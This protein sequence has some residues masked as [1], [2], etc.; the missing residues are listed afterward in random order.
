MKLTKMY[1]NWF[2]S[3]KKEEN[4]PEDLSH[5]NIY[6]NAMAMSFHNPHHGG[7]PWGKENDFGPYTFREIT[8][9]GA[10][11]KYGGGVSS[12][13]KKDMTPMDHWNKALSHWVDALQST[14]N[15]FNTITDRGPDYPQVTV[16]TANNIYDNAKAHS[17][18]ASH[19][20]AEA[21]RKAFYLGHGLD[22]R[23]KPEEY[24]SWKPP[25]FE[26]VRKQ[27]LGAKNQGVIHT[28]S[29]NHSVI[30]SPFTNDKGE[31]MDLRALHKTHTELRD[32]LKL[33][34]VEQH[35]SD[36]FRDDPQRKHDVVMGLIGASRTHREVAN[37]INE[38]RIEEALTS[39]PSK[40]RIDFQRRFGHELPKN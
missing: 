34:A 39:K 36:T 35:N 23:M 20:A 31:P 28:Y 12:E 14:Q 24:E 27:H 25:E 32:A 17:A 33:M 11:Y 4:S 26:P 1:P 40:K 7:D 8:P 3:L 2:K 13:H 16:Q 6:K 19:H 21:G 15:Y 29:G 30:I 22:P 37:L 38:I 18:A 5:E 9:T 10:I